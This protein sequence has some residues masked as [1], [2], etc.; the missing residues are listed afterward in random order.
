M[1]AR[2]RTA[3]EVLDD[4]ARE[5][6]A[7]YR[8]RPQRARVR[9]RAVRGW[10]RAAVMVT[11]V[12]VMGGSTAA[13]TRTLFAPAPPVPRLQRLAA[14]LATHNTSRGWWQLSVS[15]CAHPADGVSVLLRMREGGAGSPCG[16]LAQPPTVLLG[17]NGELVFAIVPAGTV[18]VELALGTS[19]RSVVPLAVDADVLRAAR[20]PAG[21]RAY[22]ARLKRGQAVTAAT[23]FDGAGHL[24]L[25][26]QELRC[27]TP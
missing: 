7:A 11:V 22:V 8:A 21:L 14:I 27:E 16:P 24:V 20:L 3:E 2:T 17:R 25:A 26:C 12:A 15:R 18:R 13:A 9:F 1:S 4:L 23:A 19:R 5:L 10:R 6:G